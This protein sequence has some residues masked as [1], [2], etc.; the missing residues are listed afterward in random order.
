MG[1]PPVQRPF[2]QTSFIVQNRPSSHGKPSFF[3]CEVHPVPGMHTPIVQMSSK[4]EQSIGGPFAQA[5]FE[6]VPKYVQASPSSHCAPLL[7]GCCLQLFV[8]SSQ[9]PTWQASRPGHDEGGPP[10]QTPLWHESPF[11][12]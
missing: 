7:P 12:Q 1:A 2:E 3:G 4:K 8:A 6:H 10:T 5:P 9:T 11:V